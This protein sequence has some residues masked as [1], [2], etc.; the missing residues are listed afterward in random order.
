ME[1]GKVL[2]GH[3]WYGFFLFGIKSV[4]FVLLIIIAVT[5]L[6]SFSMWKLNKEKVVI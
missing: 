3:D 6:I 1:N 2:P 4:F 5:Y